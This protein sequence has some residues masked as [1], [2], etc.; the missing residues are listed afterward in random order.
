MSAAVVHAE[1]VA[2]VKERI[3]RDEFN[4]PLTGVGLVGKFSLFVALTAIAMVAA[5]PIVLGVLTVGALALML[6]TGLKARVVLT[7]LKPLAPVVLMLFVF[8]ALFYNQTAAHAEYARIVLFPLVTTEYVSLTISVGGLLF[9]LALVLKLFLMMAVSIYLIG[10]TPMEQMLAALQALRVP[11]AIGLMMSTAVRFIPTMTGEV[12]TIKDAQRARGAGSS[13][14]KKSRRGQAVQGTLPL[15]VPMIVSSMRRADTMAMSM[16]SRGYGFTKHR[17][18]LTQLSIGP[19]DFV[20]L[21]LSIALVA[22]FFVLRATSG[23][24]IL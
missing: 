9:A 20:F 17:T 4:P 5:E 6:S 1:E 23:I 22:A 11:N 19:A 15:F 3:P 18:V 24:G 14:Q 16:V 2:A 7:A 8:S 13:F 12:A 21:T 10:T